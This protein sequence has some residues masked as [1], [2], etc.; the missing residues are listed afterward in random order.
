MFLG[1]LKICS[2]ATSLFLIL[3]S[4]QRRLLSVGRISEV[5]SFYNSQHLLSAD[6]VPDST[7]SALKLK[8]QN[9]K[10]N[11]SVGT[12]TIPIWTRKLRY[13]E[14]ET[15]LIQLESQNIIPRCS[16]SNM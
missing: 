14:K 2:E 11:L 15:C 6:F 5:L 1:L 4:A 7:V 13:E 16:G 12:F 8:P 9:S 10:T 3:E